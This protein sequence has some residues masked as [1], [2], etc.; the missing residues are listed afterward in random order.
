VLGGHPRP[1][2]SPIVANIECRTS[3]RRLAHFGV[4]PGTDTYACVEEPYKLQRDG[5]CGLVI[6]YPVTGQQSPSYRRYLVHW[7]RFGDIC[8][9]LQGDPRTVAMVQE[10]TKVVGTSLHRP[11][12]ISS[13]CC[14]HAISCQLGQHK[15]SAVFRGHHLGSN[16]RAVQTRFNRLM[17]RCIW[18][19]ASR[20]EMMLVGETQIMVRLDSPGGP[21]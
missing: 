11:D 7:S 8:T 10:G 2:F 16:D 1:S 4:R 9:V 20:S 5:D 19:V 13:A 6:S 17:Q 3:G 18:M 21:A 12:S 15:G 14:L